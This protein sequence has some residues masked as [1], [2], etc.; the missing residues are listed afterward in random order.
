MKKVFDILIGI[1][2]TIMFIAGVLNIVGS[3][4]HRGSESSQ[5]AIIGLSCI[6]TSVFLFGYSHI[7][8]AAIIYIEKQKEAE[9]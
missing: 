7:V 4:S 5:M 1:V 6:V 3:F 8:D 9:E 2:Y